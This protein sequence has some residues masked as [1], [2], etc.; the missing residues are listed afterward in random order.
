MVSRSDNEKSKAEKRVSDS[1]LFF[2]FILVHTIG[3]RRSSVEMIMKKWK[4]MVGIILLLGTIIACQ[5][6]GAYML[7][8]IQTKADT[9][10]EKEK[11]TI[12]IDAGHG[13]T[14]PGKVGINDVL[15]KDV[16]LLIAKQLNECLELKGITVVMTREDDSSMADSKSADLSARVR[17]INQTKPNLAVSIHQNSYTSESVKGAQVFYHKNSEEGKAAAEILQETLL[18]VDPKNNRQAKADTNYYLLKNTEVPLVIVECGFLSN[19]E[20]ADKLKTEEYQNQI[21]EAICTGIV[22]YLENYK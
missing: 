8:Q 9:G 21:A 11:I 14:D 12:V 4:Y 20:E 22:K 3:I 1:V 7:N 13:S 6:A 17:L 19:S 16:N 5:K 18:Q 2:I 15:E 10:E